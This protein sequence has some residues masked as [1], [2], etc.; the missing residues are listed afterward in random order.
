MK[1]DNSL[2]DIFSQIANA[3]K[4]AAP[5]P[6]AK[7]P[8]F[9]YDPEPDP[10]AA[11]DGPPQG[12]SPDG[13]AHASP[14]RGTA[15]L[16]PWLCL[17]LA[18]MAA[19]L[20]A[21]LFQLSGVRARLAALEEA[22]ASVAA[23]DQLREENE[24]LVNEK[25]R[26]D[27]WAGQKA[28]EAKQL[29]DALDQNYTR[30]N[31]LLLK[32][33]A[34]YYQWYIQRFMEEKDYPM[35]AAAVVFSADFWYIIWIRQVSV[36]PA[37]M[38][39]Y[40]EY[41]QELFDRGYL[42]QADPVR[43]GGS[44]LCFAEKWDPGENHDMAALSILWCALDAH[45]V[46]ESDEEAAQYLCNYHLAYPSSGYQSRIEQ[47]AGNFAQ[48]QFQLLKDELAE[49]QWLAIGPDGTISEGPGPASGFKNDV[50]YNLPFEPPFLPL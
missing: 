33:K 5:D 9:R 16:L 2:E 11:T 43:Y 36:N 12:F 44:N 45:F 25:G 31:D 15:A 7:G 14:G 42:Q 13:P 20:A 29:Q 48:E 28:E 39:Q 40:Q 22:V 34:L 24:S 50:L 4:P 10:P 26:L 38:E 1:E 46:R 49:S 30:M 8:R 41:C 21:C 6:P 18:V 17:L 47:V 35:A 32:E 37:L 23:V 19:A 3:P 27:A